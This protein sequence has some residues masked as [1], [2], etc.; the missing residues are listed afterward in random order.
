MCQGVGWVSCV[1]H[2][3]YTKNYFSFKKRYSVTNMGLIGNKKLHSGLG[4]LD[5]PMTRG[6]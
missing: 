4:I 3:S 1:R 5:L 6:C 2:Y